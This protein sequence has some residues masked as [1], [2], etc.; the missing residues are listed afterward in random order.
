MKIIKTAFA[1]MLMIAAAT[2]AFVRI[3][4]PS[5][6]QAM[7][8][9]DAEWEAAVVAEKQGPPKEIPAYLRKDL[10]EAVERRHWDREMREGRRCWYCKEQTHVWDS[11]WKNPRARK[12]EP[13]DSVEDEK[14]SCD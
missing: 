8:E 7:I 3:V 1:L 14:G 11:C 10:Q 6:T 13:L 5:P 2:F 9:A 12:P 4:F